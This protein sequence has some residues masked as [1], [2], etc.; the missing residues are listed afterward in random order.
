MFFLV[1]CFIILFVELIFLLLFIINYL[2]CYFE[3]C[4][5][6]MLGFWCRRF[7]LWSL[8]IIKCLNFLLFFLFVF[9]LWGKFIVIFNVLLCVRCLENSLESFVLFMFVFMILFVILLIVFSFLLFIYMC[10]LRWCIGGR[11]LLNEIWVWI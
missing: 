7:L 2:K 10:I 3:K 5:C 8:F 11:L 6:I 4:N 9:D 1:L